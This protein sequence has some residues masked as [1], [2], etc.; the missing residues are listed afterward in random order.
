MGGFL[1]GGSVFFGFIGIF[2]YLPYY[3]TGAPFGLSVVNPLL[4]T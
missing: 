1:I 2:T 3:L 4:A